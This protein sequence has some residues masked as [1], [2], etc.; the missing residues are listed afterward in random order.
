MSPPVPEFSHIVEVRDLPQN[1]A[2]YDISATETE[3]AAL[4]ERFGLVRIDGFNAK[5]RLETRARGAV[6][7]SGRIMAHVTQTCVVTLDLVEENIDVALDIVFR[8]DFEEIAQDGQ[9]LENELDFEPLTGDS[10][11]IGAIVTEEMALSL[12]PYPRAISA[13]LIGP[14]IGE[15]TEE[16][17][18]ER[19]FAA[20]EALLPKDAKI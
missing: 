11:D 6:R 19:P 7:L 9:D 13:P 2:D 14:D 12:N 8:S 16:L 10:L 3:C 17:Q 18:R 15:D 4:A 5:L 20:L 1:G